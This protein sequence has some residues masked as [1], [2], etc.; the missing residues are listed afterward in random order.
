MNVDKMRVLRV[1]RSGVWLCAEV[2]GTGELPGTVTVRGRRAHRW[3][4]AV[5]CSALALAGPTGGRITAETTVDLRAEDIIESHR[6]TT[7]AVARVA[8]IEAP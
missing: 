8:A 1:V 6:M 3:Q 5:D 4:G 2:L 7:D